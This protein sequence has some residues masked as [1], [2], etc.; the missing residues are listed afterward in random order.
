MAT[1]N[2]A[3]LKPVCRILPVVRSMI[4]SALRYYQ[5]NK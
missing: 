5:G 1:T 4:N 2:S 3:T